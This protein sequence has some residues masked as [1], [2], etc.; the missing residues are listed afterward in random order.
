MREERLATF[1]AAAGDNQFDEPAA[2]AYGRSH[3]SGFATLGLAADLHEHPL[4]FVQPLAGWENLGVRQEGGPVAADIDERRTERRQQPHDAAE[5]NAAGLTA[6]AALDEELDGN[7][8]F[9]QR[10]LPLARVR[11]DQQFA[12]QLGR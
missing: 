4:A 10:R 2:Q 5:M 6:V 8:L 3:S 12:V 7:D 9:E 11:R 1:E